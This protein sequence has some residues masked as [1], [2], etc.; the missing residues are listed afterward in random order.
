MTFRGY[1]VIWVGLF[2]DY[3]CV[4]YEIKTGGFN[5]VS[6]FIYLFIFFPPTHFLSSSKVF[7]VSALSNSFYFMG[8]TTLMNQWNFPFCQSKEE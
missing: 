8:C 2:V 6:R 1:L 7:A 5:V 4:H 3:F